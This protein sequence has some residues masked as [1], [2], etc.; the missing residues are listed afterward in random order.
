MRIT[1]DI[2]DCLVQD[3][4]DYQA[5]ALLRTYHAK[6]SE[7]TC[8]YK[9]YCSGIKKADCVLANVTKNQ[10]FV[11]FLQTPAIP[12]RRPD[13]TVFIHKPL[14]HYREVLKL[15]NVILSHTKPNHEDY[16]VINQIVHELQVSLSSHIII[17]SQSLNSSR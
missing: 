13:L 5:N 3:D 16:Y 12:R 9:K 6:V 11:R 4:G 10:E 15:F 14:E 1:E 2:L 8:A 7:I 17:N